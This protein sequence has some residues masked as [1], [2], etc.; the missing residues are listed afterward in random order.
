MKARTRPQL[1][2]LILM[3]VLG[4]VATF[5]GVKLHAEQVAYPDGISSTAT[6]S[7]VDTTRGRGGRLLHT[8]VY[9]FRTQ[10]GRDVSFPEP[11]A[12]SDRPE[13]GEVVPIS[14][15]P[16]DA[17]GARVVRGWNRVALLLV[18]LGILLGLT[19]AVLTA[20]RLAQVALRVVNR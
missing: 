8:A 17:E 10:D 1:V 7:S 13:V 12:T 14:Y 2:G 19:G 18:G 15:R 20:R 6:L 16:H 11:V 3:M 9:T 4:T 5:A